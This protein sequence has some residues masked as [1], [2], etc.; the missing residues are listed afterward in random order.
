MPTTTDS[1]ETEQLLLMIA[2]GN[3][4]ALGSLIALHR[5]YLR[6]VVDARMEP[7]LRQ[8]LDPSDVVQETLAV[9]TR[10][11]DDYLKRRPATFRLWLRGTAL[12]QLIDARRH[13]RAQKRS[14]ERDVCISDA[15]SLALAS[16][17]A[18]SGP[19]DRLLRHEAAEQVRE[20]L[21]ALTPFDREVLIM[22][23]GEGLSNA[24]TAEVL[25]VDPKTASKRYGRALQRLATQLSK[26]GFSK[27]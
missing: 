17:F 23:H 25:Q 3:R 6:R 19:S 24:D 2:A 7:G 8:K 9:A 5:D 4:D 10:R 22:R 1:S 14:L 11:I 13:H 26:L 15:S 21:A 20:A 18:G 12:E 16:A 27:G